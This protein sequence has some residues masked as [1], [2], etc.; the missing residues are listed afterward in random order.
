L[1]GSR[2]RCFA[3]FTVQVKFRIVDVRRGTLEAAEAAT[4]LVSTWR[5]NGQTVGE[6]Q[7]AASR[8]AITVYAS[9]LERS[10]LSGKFANEYVKSKLSKLSEAGL[11][12]PKVE[13]LG[14]D[15]E[16]ARPCSCKT[17]ESFIVFT[18]F[19]TIGSPLRC[20]VCFGMVPLYRIPPTDRC[21]YSDIFSWEGAYKACD[22]LQIDCGVGE[23]FGERQL[24]DCE[25]PLSREGRELCSRIEDITGTPTYYYLCRFRGRSLRRERER[26]CPNC[27]R[28]WLLEE[29]W[30]KLVD[31]RCEPCRLVS[32]IAFDL[33]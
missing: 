16:S 20:G 9:V 5:R 26:K 22:T 18:T 24:Q 17:R 8:E 10:S 28:R 31:F 12:R 1:S 21:E 7:V 27:N 23:R 29:P 2:R 30:H 19:L 4:S 13:I 14:R 3:M 15:P 6:W 32:S 33:G 11:A 25:S